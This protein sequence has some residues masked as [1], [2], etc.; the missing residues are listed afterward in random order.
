MVL[1]PKPGEWPVSIIPVGPPR[2]PEIRSAR[3]NLRLQERRRQSK[4][5]AL[6]TKCYRQ[7]TKPGKARCERCAEKIREYRARKQSEGKQARHIED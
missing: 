1:K 4:E 7:P 2:T 5:Q 3:K 6:C